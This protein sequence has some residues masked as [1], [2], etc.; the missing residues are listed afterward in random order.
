MRR[1]S[2]FLF[3]PIAASTAPAA[4]GSAIRGSASVAKAIFDL[5]SPIPLGQAARFHAVPCLFYVRLRG[6]NR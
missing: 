1:L 3:T 6:T 4:E 5:P 2:G